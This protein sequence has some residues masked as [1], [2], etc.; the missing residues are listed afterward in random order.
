MHTA[1]LRTFL[2]M[3]LM[4]LGSLSAA[5]ATAPAVHERIS[6][7]LPGVRHIQRRD[8]IS[9]DDVRIGSVLQQKLDEFLAFRRIE[10]VDAVDILDL[11]PRGPV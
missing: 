8:S 11:H 5:P 4:L 2:A 7:P 3:A 10:R 1:P 9:G 6:K